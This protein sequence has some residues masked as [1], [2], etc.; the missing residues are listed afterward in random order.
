[1]SVVVSAASPGLNA[2]TYE[3]ITSRVMPGDQLPDGCE[4]HIGGPSSRG[5]A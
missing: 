4:P 3:A 2:Q 5:G 1:M